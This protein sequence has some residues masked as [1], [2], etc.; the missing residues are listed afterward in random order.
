MACCWSKAAFCTD[1]ECGSESEEDKSEE[2][3]MKGEG[4]LSKA[5][6]NGGMAAGRVARTG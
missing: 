6:R 2:R 5:P 1:S 4:R 3:E